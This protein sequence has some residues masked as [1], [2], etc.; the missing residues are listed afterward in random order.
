MAQH[1]WRGYCISFAR[2]RREKKVHAVGNS[3]LGRAF[4]AVA[5]VHSALGAWA[6]QTDVLITDTSRMNIAQFHFI[7]FWWL[8]HLQT[9]PPNVNEPNLIHSC[10]DTRIHTQHAHTQSHQRH[11]LHVCAVQIYRWSL[12][13]QI[14]LWIIG[15]GILAHTN[16]LYIKYTRV[17]LI[18][19]CNMCGLFSVCRL[20]KLKY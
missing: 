19:I 1:K 9:A 17:Y 12:Y 14:S 6:C 4:V 11:T 3:S 10:T 7:F 15:H 8:R 18:I 13:I 5:P 2:E 16:I 20:L